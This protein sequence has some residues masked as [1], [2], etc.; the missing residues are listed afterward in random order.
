MLSYLSPFCCAVLKPKL[1]FPGMRTGW[2]LVSGPTP[3][4]LMVFWWPNRLAIHCICC[5]FFGMPYDSPQTGEFYLGVSNKAI[6]RF[7]CLDY[8]PWRSIFEC[9]KNAR[10]NATSKPEFFWGQ[11]P[12]IPK[13]AGYQKRTYM[14]GPC[15]LNLDLV[16]TRTS[17]AKMLRKDCS[18]GQDVLIAGFSGG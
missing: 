11:S 17:P 15:G 13:M 16:P 14:C 12:K 6:Y 8:P 2:R 18:I 4:D 1:V 3:L 7:R 5:M 9:F 10:N